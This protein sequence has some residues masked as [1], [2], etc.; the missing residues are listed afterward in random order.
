MAKSNGDAIGTP[1]LGE[2]WLYWNNDGHLH[3]ACYTGTLV[4]MAGPALPTDGVLH[5]VCCWYDSVG[6]TI[7]VQVDMGAVLFLPRT[8]SIGLT[9]AGK[10][11][12][13]KLCNR[14]RAYC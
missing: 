11:R 14:R 6:Q 7:N 2:Y 9:L 1:S 5:F 8:S 10:Q 13:A 3:F 12:L 4:D